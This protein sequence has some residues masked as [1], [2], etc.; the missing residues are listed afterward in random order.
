VRE[1]ENLI[2]KLKNNKVHKGEV[3]S[4]FSPFKKDIEEEFENYFNTKVMISGEF[5]KGTIK[6]IYKSKEDLQHIINK[7]RGMEDYDKNK[8]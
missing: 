8:E 5:H 6:I 2:K 1:T 7:I 4:T 3:P